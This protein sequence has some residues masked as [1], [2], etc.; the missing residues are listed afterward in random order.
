MLVE[1]YTRINHLEQIIRQ[2]HIELQFYRQKTSNSQYI[3]EV[4]A[5]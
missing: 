3:N 2:L 4:L 5:Y 1:A